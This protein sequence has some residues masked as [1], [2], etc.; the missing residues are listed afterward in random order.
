[1]IFTILSALAFTVGTGQ[2]ILTTNGYGKVYF[3]MHLDAAEA[4]VGE[5]DVAAGESGVET[6]RYVSFASL[7]NVQFMAE[8]NVI[9]RADASRGVENALHI[10]ID[11]ALS[12]VTAKYPAVRITAHKY[13]ADGRY[14]IFEGADRKTAIVFEASGGK[15]T[16]V[17][18]GPEPSVE[19]VEGCL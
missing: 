4:A 19:Y 15:I 13:D 18:A 14:V 9:T 12:N 16:K 8:N 6:C 1:M 11:G 5:K 2:P 3:G 7:P 10:S 17:R